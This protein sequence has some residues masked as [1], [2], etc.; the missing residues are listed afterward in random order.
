LLVS[1]APPSALDRYFYFV[2]VTTQDSLFRHVVEATFGERPTRDKLPWLDAL[3]TAGYFL[4]HVSPDP[5][6]DRDVLPPLLPALARRCKQLDPERIVVIGARL[7]DLAYDVLRAARLPVVD[8]RFP[9][10]G[11]GQQRRFLDLATPLL[12]IDDADLDKS[13]TSRAP[14]RS[15]RS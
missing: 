11:S 10:P 4:I 2:D 14:S 7:Y 8:A 3:K 12:A 15:G 13:A 1:E 9:I 5:F 6:D